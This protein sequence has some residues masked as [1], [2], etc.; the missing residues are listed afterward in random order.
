MALDEARCPDLSEQYANALATTER[1]LVLGLAS[2]GPCSAATNSSGSLPGH[3]DL[4]GLL[5]SG[6]TMQLRRNVS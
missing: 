1:S 4:S 3:F 5:L 2:I 6:E